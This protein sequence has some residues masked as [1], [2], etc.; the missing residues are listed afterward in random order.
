MENDKAIE[1]GEYVR[2]LRKEQKLTL[3]EL[4]KASDVSQPYL[5]NIENGNRGI[6]S[7]EIL[8]KLAGPLGVPNSTLL[9]RAGYADMIGRL[10]LAKMAY[11]ASNLNAE[12]LRL[13]GGIEIAMVNEDRFYTRFTD[14][15]DEIRD[16]I[17]N[18]L[19]GDVFELDPINFYKLLTMLNWN[20]DN[21]ENESVK[22]V[23]FEALQNLHEIAKAEISVNKSLD[24]ML[25]PEVEPNYKGIS[26]S[27]K[28]KKLIA[29][30][31]D[32]M[33]N[34]QIEHEEG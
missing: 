12:V 15:M 31:L 14:D 13:W 30:Y 28:E 7:I 27:E 8:N 3:V 1:F 21:D 26:I 34:D 2:S 4:A 11:G 9:L 18:V 17:R 19:T 5:S 33:Y 23:V 20:S 32:L 10:T 25:S 6:P 16:S 24:L 22:E 29:A